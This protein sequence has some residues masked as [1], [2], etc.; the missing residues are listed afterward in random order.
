M[1]L[2]RQCPPTATGCRPT[3]CPELDPHKQAQRGEKVQAERAEQDRRKSQKFPRGEPGSEAESHTERA[4]QSSVGNV[5][6][7]R[8][9]LAQ[10]VQ[11][12]LKLLDDV[13]CFRLNVEAQHVPQWVRP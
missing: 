7:F 4:P 9:H 8:I 5:D 12:Q 2:H 6:D 11:G 10:L 13:G 3:E 1:P